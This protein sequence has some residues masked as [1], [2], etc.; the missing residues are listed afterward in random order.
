MLSQMIESDALRLLGE[1]RVGRMGCCL[2]NIPY[3]VPVHYYFDGQDI[4]IHSLPG[5]KIDMLRANPNVCLQADDI[6]DEYNWRSV[7]ATG[8]FEELRDVAEHDTALA[9]LFR[10]MPLLTPVEAGMDRRSPDSIV[11][12]I[13]PHQV[14]GVFESWSR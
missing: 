1:L 14:T 8:S 7:I 6:R 2:D 12:R 9:M 10:H 13:R 11:F 4:Y 3:V 5:K